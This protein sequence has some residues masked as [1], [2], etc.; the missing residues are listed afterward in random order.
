MKDKLVTYRQLKVD[1]KIMAQRDLT[2]RIPG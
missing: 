2:S 1:Q